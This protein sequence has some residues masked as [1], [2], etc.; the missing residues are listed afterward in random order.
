MET[1]YATQD[2][3]DNRLNLLGLGFETGFY[4]V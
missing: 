3:R 2:M 1:N 4:G